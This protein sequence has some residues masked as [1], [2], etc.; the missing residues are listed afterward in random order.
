M[1]G[2]FQSPCYLCSDDRLLFIQGSDEVVDI[3]EVIQ[4]FDVFVAKLSYDWISIV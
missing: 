4:V 1:F 2:S 3:L